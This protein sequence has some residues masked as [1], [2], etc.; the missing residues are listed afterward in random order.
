MSHMEPVLSPPQR[1]LCVVAIF[2]GIPSGSLCGGERSRTPSHELLI[3]MSNGNRTITGLSGVQ[4][5]L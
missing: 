5:G 3:V 1:P 2:I 4:F